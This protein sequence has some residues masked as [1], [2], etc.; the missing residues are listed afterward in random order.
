MPVSESQLSIPAGETFLSATYLRP[1]Q[2]SA[3]MVLAHGAGAGKEH[4]FMAGFAAAMAERGVATLR[5]NFAYRDAGR[6]FPDRPPAAIAA[7][8]AAMGFAAGL[9]PGLPL[10]AAGKSFG[11]R[12][13][14]MAV[15]EGMEAAGLLYLGYPLHPPGKPEKLRDAHLYG[16]TLPMLFLQGSRDTF[17]TPEILE[18]VV[19]RIGPAAEL[20]WIEGGDHSFAVAGKKRSADAIG[21]SVA[22]PAADF[23]LARG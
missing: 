15:A 16:L 6:K 23:I 12:M 13:A 11:G 18:D 9:E 22:E 3:M 20:Q 17:A 8:R 5:F 19:R 14:S 4:P 1:D 10:W 2:P 21:A 7:W